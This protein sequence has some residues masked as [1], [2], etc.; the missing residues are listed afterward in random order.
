MIDELVI[1]PGD[2]SNLPAVRSILYAGADRDA[3]F[4]GPILVR[5]DEVPAPGVPLVAG[6]GM[7]W[8][9]NALDIELTNPHAHLKARVLW[10][11]DT[12]I[13][14]P[15]AAARSMLLYSFRLGLPDVPG[16]IETEWLRAAL[17]PALVVGPEPRQLG[18]VE[19]K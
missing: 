10:S 6:Q 5:Q 14:R 1:G 7:Y 4:A 17:I 9:Q 12:D 2:T 18:G 11:D 16:D 19:V 15:L 13:T 8:P 3:V